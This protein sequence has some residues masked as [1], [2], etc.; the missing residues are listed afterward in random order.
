LSLFWTFKAAVPSYVSRVPA[1]DWEWY[2]LLQHHGIPTRLLDWTQSALVAMYFALV[3]RSG[4]PYELDGEEKPGVWVLNP[5]LLNSLSH[6]NGEEF[7]LVPDS[8]QIDAWLPHNCVRGSKPTPLSDHPHFV[9]NAKPLA[10]FPKRY[11][12]RIVAQRGLFTVHGTE[13]AALDQIFSV[14]QPQLIPTMV[15]DP[16]LIGIG[17]SLPPGKTPK[18]ML[19]A[20]ESSGIPY[21]PALE[22]INL[23]QK[24]TQRMVRDLRALGMDCAALFPEADSIAKDLLRAYRVSE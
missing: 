21:R 11:N 24:H 1:D 3:S 7:V 10:I 23:S 2:Y 16:S 22:V 13:E 4:D 19:L 15:E 12:P 18:E 9:D 17:L 6:K 14:G 5:G 8:P 20:A